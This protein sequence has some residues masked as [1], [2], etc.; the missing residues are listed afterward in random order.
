M[1]RWLQEHKMAQQLYS[2]GETESS[3]QPSKENAYIIGVPPDDP[4]LHSPVSL[5]KNDSGKP[6]RNTFACTNCH[7]LKQKC[8]PS[9]INNIYGKPCQRCMKC[10]RT[11]KFDLSK[12][13]R[14]KKRKMIH[15]Y[16]ENRFSSSPSAVDNFSEEVK[17]P[18]IQ[19]S[20]MDN[21][22]GPLSRFDPVK[23]TATEAS[24]E[25]PLSGSIKGIKRLKNQT[26]TA[27]KARTNRKSPLQKELQA[28]LSMQK[29]KLDS[30]SQ[31]LTD[32]STKWN[33]IVENNSLFGPVSD[34]VTLKIITQSES[35]YRLHLYRTKMNQK[36]K[37]PFVNIPSDISA[38]QLRSSQPI[39]FSV[40]MSVVS[41]ILSKDQSTTKLTM[42]L[43]N[44]ALGLI[45]HQVMR[46]GNK[47]IELLKSLLILCMWYNFPELSHKTRYHFFNYVCCCLIRDLGPTNKGKLFM[48]AGD[49]T[50]QQQ[51]QQPAKKTPLENDEDHQRLILLVYVSSLNISIFLRQST[52]MRWSSLLERSCSELMSGD[53]KSDVYGTQDDHLLVLFTKLNHVLEKVHMILHEVDS[54]SNDSTSYKDRS[55]IIIDLQLQLESIFQKI[56]KERNRVLAFFY[57][58]EAYLHEYTFSKFIDSIENKSEL[59]DLPAPVSDSFSKCC[60]SC[61]NA[62]NEFLKLT[63]ELIAS[64][65]LYHISRIIYTVGMLLLRL[66]YVTMTVAAFRHLQPM[67][68]QALPLVKKISKLLDESFELFPFNN[69]LCKLRYVV[70]LFIQTYANK[71]TYVLE[72]EDE[73]LKNRSN[74]LK[75]V[76]IASADSGPALSST[77]YHQDR[78]INSYNNENIQS[79]VIGETTTNII[80]NPILHPL[81]ASDLLQGQPPIMSYQSGIPS[82]VRPSNNTTPS[83]DMT[84]YLADINSLEFGY[85]ALNDEFW[86][87]VFMNSM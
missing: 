56:P 68:A 55:E 80:A 23:F 43:D 4:R 44:L 66:R 38:E 73:D 57:S 22:I 1:S 81:L 83:E 29:G 78:K 65:P 69:F 41:L 48:P 20:G 13:T 85:N 10:N 77:A 74:S 40:I 11:C 5:S 36:F 8:V 2:E 70:A 82:N 75:N 14:K 33:E 52:Q 60:Q 72:H 16:E 27:T 86:T 87:D 49:N 71:V 18:T 21:I 17:D 42:Q 67:T 45:S 51:Q 24:N 53:Y 19:S 25:P 34:P 61:T 84:N 28:L 7:S 76:M 31:K 12:R 39:L 63:P 9:D 46:L 47:S 79:N 62:M 58:V 50:Q 54:Y 59:H 32:L 37:L 30:I 35:E 6:K 26:S 3:S 15:E 64:L